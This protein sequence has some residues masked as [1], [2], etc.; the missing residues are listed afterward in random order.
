MFI[1]ENFNLK[2]VWFCHIN[3]VEWELKLS[4]P[5]LCFLS[6]Q[7][8]TL[9]S[10]QSQLFL[11]CSAV[12]SH[13]SSCS[14]RLWAS[15]TCSGSPFFRWVVGCQLCPLSLLWRKIRRGLDNPQN[16]RPSVNLERVTHGSLCFWESSSASD[17]CDCREAMTVFES[18]LLQV[19]RSGERPRKAISE[20]LL[21]CNCSAFA[22][23]LW[24][25]RG[26]NFYLQN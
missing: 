19:L 11:R 21:R 23:H 18:S 22:L 25:R 17:V 1:L 20:I 2:W 12:T 5:S 24:R 16:Q 4:P 7:R 10:C 13:P 26:K 9:R 3:S 6:Q 14:W 8:R 15:T